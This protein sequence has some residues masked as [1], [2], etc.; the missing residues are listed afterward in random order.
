[1]N[2]L[3]LLKLFVNMLLKI[4]IKLFTIILD[5]ILPLKDALL[6]LFLVLKYFLMNKPMEVISGHFQ[7]IVGLIKKD[8]YFEDCRKLIL[9]EFNNINFF[10]ILKL[11]EIILD[12]I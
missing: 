3:F 4:L 2:D 6:F 8:V 10:S 1:M 5:S 9:T 11:I 12:C 7:A